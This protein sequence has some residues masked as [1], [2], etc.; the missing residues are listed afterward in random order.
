MWIQ[1]RALG[2]VNV[3]CKRH[4]H[5]FHVLDHTIL[6]DV[7]TKPA[8]ILSILLAELEKPEE[9]RLAWLMWVDADTVV[10]NPLIPLSLFLPPA[11]D[12]EFGDVNFLVT[13]DDNGLNNGVFFVRV[14]ASSVELFSAIV[15][16][17]HYHPQEQLQFRDQTAME[18]ILEEPKFPHNTKFVPQYWFN[19]YR[20]ATP[21]NSDDD[22][23]IRYGGFLIHFAGVAG[24]VEEMEQWLKRTD[25]VEATCERDFL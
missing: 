22:G 11:E 1:H 5:A 15:S 24:R 18:R 14:S 2:L 3:L 10:M 4:G 21:E 17:R 13:K 25:A 12:E 7:W 19:A 8:Y 9:E 16:Y 23:K 20:S 6:D